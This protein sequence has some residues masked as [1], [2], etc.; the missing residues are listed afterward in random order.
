MVLATGEPRVLE[1]GCL[2]QVAGQVAE[3]RPGLWAAPAHPAGTD[4][5]PAAVRCSSG[6]SEVQLLLSPWEPMLYLLSAFDTLVGIVFGLNV[7]QT[8]LL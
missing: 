5:H 7:L 1:P 8:S 4:S 2:G 6:A 3:G